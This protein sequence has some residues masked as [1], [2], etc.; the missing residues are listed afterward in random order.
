MRHEEGNWSKNPSRNLVSRRAWFRNRG[1]FTIL[2]LDSIRKRFPWK[3]AIPGPFCCQLNLDLHFYAICSLGSCYLKKDTEGSLELL[4]P[5]EQLTKGTDLCQLVLTKKVNIILVKTVTEES[6]MIYWD[7]YLLGILVIVS[8]TK[9]SKI[10]RHS[11][12]FLRSYSQDSRRFWRM[13]CKE[14]YIGQT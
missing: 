6:E 3:C 11:S 8:V 14:A 7:R 13:W 12:H 10:I 5:L 1:N 4:L 9:L 2:G